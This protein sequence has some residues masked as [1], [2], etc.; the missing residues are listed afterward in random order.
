MRLRADS[1]EPQSVSWLDAEPR[2]LVRER[3]AVSAIAP[4]LEWIERPAGGWEGFAPAWPFERAAPEGLDKFL[5]GRRL[6]IQVEYS[7]AFPMVE[8]K[9][10]PVDPSPDPRYRTQAIWHVNP[11]GSLC[12]LQAA[13]D[14]TGHETAADLVVK[15]AGWF[16]EYLL[17]EEGLIERM[18]ESGIVNDDALDHLFDA[19]AK[20]RDP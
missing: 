11:D 13:S 5:A 8:P 1:E 15:A 9:I 2:R 7:Q 6:R 3:E 10:W 18:T 19:P 17:M 4:E 14:W 20:H 16:L 12:L